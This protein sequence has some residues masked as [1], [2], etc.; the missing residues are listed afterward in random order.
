MSQVHMG[1]AQTQLSRSR[2]RHILPVDNEYSEHNP[3]YPRTLS[4]IFI[5]LV[6]LAGPGMSGQGEIEVDIP[7]K[8]A[9]RRWG[10]PESEYVENKIGGGKRKLARKVWGRV[11]T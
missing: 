6:T 2:E 11:W 8:D 9:S 10:S 1:Q 5:P 7:W 3:E 4:I